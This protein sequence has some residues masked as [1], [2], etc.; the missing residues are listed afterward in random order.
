MKS[1]RN[2]I[3][4]IKYGA[5]TGTKKRPHFGNYD[6]YSNPKPKDTVRI[7]YATLSDIKFTIKKLESLYA[8]KLR[9]HARISKI[10]NVLQQR[11]RVLKEKNP[12]NSEIAKRHNLAKSYFEFLKQRTKQNTEEARRELKFRL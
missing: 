8:R 9:P 12:D 6:I 4:N 11:M 2:S 1:K 3:S 10:A 7:K 5:K